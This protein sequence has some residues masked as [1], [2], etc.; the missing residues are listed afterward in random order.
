ML[1]K[2]LLIAIGWLTFLTACSPKN[3]SEKYYFQHEKVLD[4]IEESYKDLYKERPFTIAFTDKRFKTISIEIITDSLTYI[5]DFDIAEKRITDTLLKY[6]L[7]ASKIST[8][9][10]QMQSIR[11]AWVNNFE[12]YVEEKK[13]SLI[14]MSIKPVALKALFSYHKYYILTYFSQPQQF[15]EKGRLLDQRELRRLRKINGE[16]FNRINDKVCYTISGTF[17]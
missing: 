12:Y 13:N 4:K 17:R 3:I 7:N 14:F 2:Y 9:I 1:N 11:C 15:D 16:I 10:T 8:L 6:Q 5:Y